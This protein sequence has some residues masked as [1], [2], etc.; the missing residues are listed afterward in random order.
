MIE[1]E[2]DSAGE[3]VLQLPANFKEPP[4]E[5]ML[6]PVD[7]K[8][9]IHFNTSFEVDENA[10]KCICLACK[11]EVTPMFVLK[12]LMRL[13]SQWMRTRAAYQ[14]EMKRL[15]ERERTKCRHCGKL[16]RISHG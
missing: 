16:T 10:G 2:I 14:D 13:E 15:S 3:K 7:A 6:V 4:G 9:C 8:K 11:E 12:Q 5:R 1:I